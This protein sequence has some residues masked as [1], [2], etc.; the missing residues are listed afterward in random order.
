MADIHLW[1]FSTISGESQMIIF[2]IYLEFQ[3]FYLPDYFCSGY[4]HHHI[5]GSW[6]FIKIIFQIFFGQAIPIY[7]KYMCAIK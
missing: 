5:S 2:Q 6:N 1:Y 7:G 4:G 3:I